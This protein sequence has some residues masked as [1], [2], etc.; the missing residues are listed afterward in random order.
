MLNVVFVP[1]LDGWVTIM[2]DVN[3]QIQRIWV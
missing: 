1:I 3:I 2:E